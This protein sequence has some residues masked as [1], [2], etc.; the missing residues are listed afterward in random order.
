[1]RLALSLTLIENVVL[2]ARLEFCYKA[3]Q[4]RNNLEEPAQCL[5]GHKDAH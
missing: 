4:V 3:R 2:A 5:N 1:M